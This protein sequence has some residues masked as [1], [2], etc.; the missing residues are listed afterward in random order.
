MFVMQRIV[1][2]ESSSLFE[3]FH[4]NGVETNVK[5]HVY[6]MLIKVFG[7]KTANQRMALIV[8]TPCRITC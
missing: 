3:P 8:K 5:V 7:H 4:T 2:S 1:T 6:L